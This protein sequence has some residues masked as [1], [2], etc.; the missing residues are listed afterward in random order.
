MYSSLIL[1]PFLSVIILN[2]PF[3]SFMKKAA[4]WVCLAVLLAQIC[5]IL[6]PATCIWANRLDIFGS[7]LK[8]NFTVDNLS[9][10]MLFCISIVLIATLFLEKYI[11]RDVERVFNFSNMILL[12]LAGMDGVVMVRDIFSLYVFL[13]I[14]AICSYIL[15]GF[16]KDI[17]AFEA[18]FK[19]ITISIV[20]TVLLLAS[21]SFLL[22]IAGNTSFSFLSG[23]LQASPDK[24]LIAFAISI[25]LGACFIKSGLVP[26]H[27]WLP[28]AYSAAPASVA[29]LL[30]GIVTKT[31][32]V[33]TLIRITY[34]VFGLDHAI[35]SILLLVGALSV[36][37]GAIAA[38]GQSD[39]K[40][41]L[42]YS[43]ISQVG[44][45]ILGLGCG[46]PLGLAGAVF[47]LFNHSIFKSLLFLNSAALELGAGSTDM[48]R[49]SGLAKKMPV[50]AT[51]SVL[52]SLSCAGIPPLAG[53]WSKLI[54]IIALWLSGFR[55]YAVI[56]V[57]ASVLTLAYLLSSQRRVFFGAQL[58]EFENIKEAGFGIIFP[59]IVLALI[60]VVVGLFFPY[61]ISVVI[62]PPGN[63]MG[64]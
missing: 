11:I 16:N 27:G 32:G 13:E 12:I 52:A 33:Y 60:I 3:R 15:I 58:K 19:Y 38:L 43:S 20:A 64:G 30:A 53:F 28:D 37:S 8:F 54:I 2:L 25:F 23:A 41:M 17:R 62:L 10:I 1:L 49:L 22:L 50:T 6:A 57:L 9:R 24:L 40:R 51:T 48:D 61:I 59:A 46:T 21:I 29:V 45:I 5:F 18:A 56:A 39:F 36:V 34:S 35:K 42:A 7:F 14:S 47:H 4:F 31:V 26:F 55:S 44:Y 63:L